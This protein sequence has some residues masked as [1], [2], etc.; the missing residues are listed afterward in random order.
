MEKIIKSI[1]IILSGI[2]AIIIL[3]SIQAFIFDN[4]P[5]IGIETRGMK[6]IGIL[7]D[8]HHCGNGKHDTVIK[9]FSYSCKYNGGK[10]TL[11]DKTKEIEDFSCDTVLEKFYEDEKYVYYWNCIKNNYMLVKYDDGNEGTIS[12]ALNKNHIDINI[13]DKFNIEYIK[14]EK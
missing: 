14:T 3:D 13:L 10:Y 6:R 1:L 7:V 5:I 8:T 4:N 9:G 12:E 11:I 2:V